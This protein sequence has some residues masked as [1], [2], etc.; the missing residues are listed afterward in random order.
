MNDGDLSIFYFI[1]NAAQRQ[2]YMIEMKQTK[3]KQFKWTQNCNERKKIPF[4]PRL[5]SFYSIKFSFDVTPKYNYF[6][7]SVFLFIVDS[8]EFWYCVYVMSIFI[9]PKIYQHFDYNGFVKYRFLI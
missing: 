3:E 9:P 8:M 5:N 2:R 6:F 1:Y 4:F 7:F